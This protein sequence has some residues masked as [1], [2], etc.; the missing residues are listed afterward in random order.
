MGGHRGGGRGAPAGGG[1]GG[2]WG[3][4]IVRGGACRGAV[5]G[6]V[7]RAGVCVGEEGEAVPAVLAKGRLP[8]PI[9]RRPVSGDCGIPMAG[10]W[11]WGVHTPDTVGH[12]P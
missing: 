2:G 9:P 5:G 6:P 7:C 1:G 12:R 10:V 8:F 11:H 4:H 3:Q